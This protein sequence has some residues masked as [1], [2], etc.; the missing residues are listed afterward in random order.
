MAVCQSR[1]PK[2][3]YW[4][5][6]NPWNMARYSSPAWQMVKAAVEE[7]GELNGNM[8]YQYIEAHYRDKVNKNTVSLQLIASS[9]N[10]SS[11]R[12][13]DDPNR[14]LWYLGNGYFRAYDPDTD[15]VEIDPKWNI[16]RLSR[17][18]V[19]KSTTNELPFSRVE[20]G[21]RITLPSQVVQGLDIQPTD[22]LAFL[23]QDGKYFLKKGRLKIEVE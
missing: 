20:L 13:F 5:P 16:I 17:P 23:E 10:H 22:I 18:P 14:F 15:V 8:A 1:L 7:L 21:N 12:S 4:N 2:D 3:L 9:V 19:R 6:W 11:A